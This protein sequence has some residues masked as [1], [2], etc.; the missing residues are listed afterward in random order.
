MT[1]V[2]AE[3][4]AVLGRY[5][6][7]GNVREL[8]NVIYRSAII[9]QGDAILVNDLP[10]E[11]RS[12]TSTESGPGDEA[13]ASFAPFDN[14]SMAAAESGA[15][16]SARIAAESV[17]TGEPSSSPPSGAFDFSVRQPAARQAAAADA[18]G[19]GDDQARRRG[20]SNGDLRPPPPNWD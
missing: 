15:L 18:I 11:I 19:G 9:A 17:A 12:A 4:L 1:R 16:A 14:V 6:W 2:S 7:P 5:P 10:A 20:G 8:E 13:D 3:A